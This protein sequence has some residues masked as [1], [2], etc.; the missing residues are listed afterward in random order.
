MYLFLT[1][2]FIHGK[3]W[4]RTIVITW[5]END[6]KVFGVDRLT[7]HFK[8]IFLISVS[9]FFF[10]YFP[11][12]FTRFIK[13]P[14]AGKSSVGVAAPLKSRAAVIRLI[15]HLIIGLFFYISLKWFIHGE[16]WSRNNETLWNSEVK[17]NWKWTPRDL[18]VVM[19]TTVAPMVCYPV[20]PPDQR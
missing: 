13:C 12:T 1:F 4:Q 20:L 11:H 3:L 9:F 6:F 16:K 18:R 17:S 15:L 2:L 8:S 10:L 19:A 5:L 7:V 14:P